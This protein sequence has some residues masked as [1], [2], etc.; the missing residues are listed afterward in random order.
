VS[1]QFVAN[2][3]AANSNTGTVTIDVLPVNDAPSA[4]TGVSATIN[5]DTSAF[6]TLAELLAGA[7]DID[8]GTLS[9]TALDNNGQIFASFDT[10]G[11]HV[12]GFAV[13]QNGPAVGFYTVSDGQGGTS[14]GTI[15]L[16]ILPVN[17]APTVASQTFAGTEDAPRLFS[18]A[19]LL[20]D[21]ADD[22]DGDSLSLVSITS[23]SGGMV[24]VTGDVVTFTPNADFN[25]TAWFFLTVTDGTLTGGNWQYIDFADVNDVPTAAAD[26]VTRSGADP[27]VIA[28]SAL[29]ANDGDIDSPQAGWSV[30]LGTATGGTVSLNGNGDVVFDFN[31]S[32]VGAYSFTYQVDDGEGG[33]S[34]LATV[35]LNTAPDAAEDDATVAEN[36]AY[37]SWQRVEVLDNDNDAD[38]DTL[39]VTGASLVGS[40]A[41]I[42]VSWDAD[43]VRFYST[44][45]AWFGAFEISYTIS[46]GRG[47]TDTALVR[48]TVTPSD[49]APTVTPD[50]GNST[51]IAST[52]ELT[53]IVIP[54]SALLANDSHEDGTSFTIT[55]VEIFHRGTA[56]LI[57]TDADTIM[58]SVRFTPQVQ[59]S[60]FYDYSNSWLAYFYYTVTDAD[61]DTAQTYAYVRVNDVNQA[62]DAVGETLAR[63]ASPQVIA[64]DTLFVN[65]VDFDSPVAGWTISAITNQN[66]VTV[67][68]DNTART[69]TVTYDGGF[70][71]TYGF[72]Y[73]LSDG[74]G[75]TDTASVI[76]DTAPQ[77]TGPVG[78]LVLNEDQAQYVSD[79]T[80]IALAGVT[81][82]DG[83]PLF[84]V[85]AVAG[86]N[87]YALDGFNTVYV[88]NDPADWNG[89]TELTFTVSDGHPGGQIT[90]TIPVTITA[91]NDAPRDPQGNDQAL[92]LTTAEDTP[93][94]ISVATLL[95]DDANPANEVQS[96]SLHDLAFW[97]NGNVVNNNNGTLTFSP[98]ANFNGT[99]GFWY[100][101]QDEQGAVSDY[102]WVPI[103]VTPVEDPVD[104]VNDVVARQFPNAGTQR[105]AFSTLLGND[106]DPDSDGTITS[107]TAGANV[108][109]VVIDGNEV[110]V[111]YTSGAATFTYTLS[112][113]TS[114]DT[115][116]VTLNS[117]PVQTGTPGTLTINEDQQ[118]YLT[119]DQLIALAGVTDPNGDNLY[120][121][122]Y[123]TNGNFSIQRFWWYSEYAYYTP[124]PLD[125]NGDTTLTF[126]I[127]DGN[128]AT[129]LT[130]TIDV[131]VL[132]INDGPRDRDSVAGWGNNRD[133][134]FY[135]TEDTDLVILKADLLADDVDPEGGVVSFAQAYNAFSLGYIFAQDE[136]SITI[137]P[138][139]NASGEGLGFYYYS[140]DALGQWS[141]PIYVVI[142][143]AETPDAINAIDDTITRSGAS[144]TITAAQMTGNDVDPDV[145]DTKD[146]VSVSAVNGLT[147]VV[148]N[149]NDS[150]T[151]TYDASYTGRASYTYT[152]Q[153]SQGNSDTATVELNR[154]PVAV[155]DGTFTLDEGQ[156][157][158]FIAYSTLLA[159]DSDADGD[160][161]S[162]S[163][164]N[165]GYAGS[166]VS[167]STGWFEGGEFGLR[168]YLYDTTYTGPAEFQYRVWD[169]DTYS[170]I[171][172]VT[173]NSVEGNDA[174]VARHDYWFYNG[175]VYNDTNPAT[176]PMAGTEDTVLEFAASL[177][178]DGQFIGGSYVDGAD[179]DEDGDAISI[180]AGSLFSS[181]GTVQLIGDNIV[182]TPNADVNSGYPWGSQE[183]YAIS[184][185]YRVTDGERESSTAT[186]YIY[187]APVDDAPITEDD[188]FGVFGNGPWTLDI[189]NLDGSYNVRVNDRSPD[190]YPY[191]F[192]SGY[193]TI[194][195]VYAITG[196]A[197]L[198]WD[199]YQVTVT[200]DGSGD[201]IVF[202]YVITDYD[203]DSATAQ[204][205]L[206]PLGQE[207]QRFYFSGSVPDYGRELWV[208]DPASYDEFLGS[209][210]A[211]MV[212]EADMQPGPDSGDPREIT[213]LGGTVFWRGSQIVDNEGGS[214][215][216]Y[217]WHAYSPSLGYIQLSRDV[218]F[219]AF[220][221][222]LP[223]EQQNLGVRAGDLFW[224]ASYIEG[225]SLIAWNQAGAE[226]A[227]VYLPG[228]DRELLTDAGGQPAY[229][230][231]DYTEVWNPE[232]GSTESFDAEQLFAVLHNSWGWEVVRITDDGTADND[233]REIAATSVQDDPSGSGLSVKHF[234]FAG[235]FGNDYQGSFTNGLWRVTTTTYGSGWDSY[236]QAELISDQLVAA[237]PHDLTIAK[238]S[239]GAGGT[240]D[241][242]FWFQ[243]NTDGNGEL[244]TRREDYFGGSSSST[245]TLFGSESFTG[246]EIRQW[247]DGVVFSGT[248]SGGDFVALYVDH[249][250]GV[251]E[252]FYIGVVL[253]LDIAGEVEQLV[254][255]GLGNTAWIV[256]DGTFDTVWTYNGDSVSFV[257]SKFGEVTDLQMAGGDIVY[258]AQSDNDPYFRTLF[259]YDIAS[260][261]LIEVPTDE[262]TEAGPAD[263]FG[264]YSGNV[265]IAGGL[266][267]DANDGSGTRLWLTDGSTITDVGGTRY[268][269]VVGY[270]GD[271]IGGG[272]FDDGSGAADGL[273]R[274]TS[275]GVVTQ[276]DDLDGIGV[277]GE[278]E[279]LGDRV[280]YG[281]NAGGTPTVRA[282]DLV[283]GTTSTV[284]AGYALGTAEQVGSEMIFS[285]WHAATSTWDLFSWNGASATYLADLPAT[286]V[287]Y[288]PSGEWRGEL[289]FLGD[290]DH[291]FFKYLSTD[292]GEEVFVLDRAT[293]TIAEL[294]IRPG[295]DSGANWGDGVFANGRV[296]FQASADGTA[297][298]M[299]LYTTTD[300]SDL[301]IV[302]GPDLST[303]YQFPWLPEVIGNTVYFLANS[304]FAASNTWAVFAVNADGISGNADDTT[305]TMIS[306]DDFSFIYSLEAI[307]GDLYFAEFEGSADQA[308]RMTPGAAP[309]QLTSFINGGS[310]SDFFEGG[311][312][313]I[314]FARDDGDY[315]REL[316]VLDDAEAVG[317]RLV[318][319]INSGF[320]NGGYEPERV[321]PAPDSL[322]YLRMLE[323]W[324]SSGGGG[325]IET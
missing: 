170:N 307:G 175:A 217:R 98:N 81:D 150:V 261:T 200:A 306:P 295:A 96:V 119:D 27:Q 205:T 20:A 325:G 174:P 43:E 106:I 87:L 312:G 276:L 33:L 103:T 263:G 314:Y 145:G 210:F 283:G 218:A 197:T 292:F 214:Y 29:F 38:G 206:N 154:A 275:A 141:A 160:P 296:F 300:G 198:S 80:L 213:A 6:F 19:A 30:V 107:V 122:G 113:G 259:S 311:D 249:D 152:V 289:D 135:G 308:W 260:A 140:Q 146:I 258:V 75:G 109:S 234:Y 299:R 47:A 226:V 279:L 53:P 182:F 104:A 148:L 151:V 31:P 9:V 44:D 251:D 184:F 215:A 315:G 48:V 5:E 143:L 302:T 229:A 208:Y 63:S 114:T 165:W 191:G 167:I 93:I 85:S 242:L 193:T 156:N 274:I 129:D 318:A 94:V 59:N 110:V 227:Q 92:G 177:L 90:V 136:T 71:G 66:G 225:E 42:V 54:F 1:F 22:V 159:N 287:A 257:A 228:Y 83:D 49:D 23:V 161:I 309:V 79:A 189:G 246:R 236:Q 280:L 172:T 288:T 282:H 34:G 255:D 278:V 158:V 230:A 310:V 144:Q 252:N 224:G 123:G 102:V 324:Y 28:K 65:D 74:E 82:A 223:L 195:D 91:V 244:A 250:T 322:D 69:V 232:T 163:P 169:G 95:A 298:S 207:P 290:S 277:R 134:I 105:I 15:T 13:N 14:T 201:P 108:S 70:A 116:T 270:A 58:D 256:D 313:A 196:I 297:D 305:A 267:F 220:D 166:N 25:G 171:V 125:F 37:N 41:P 253:M 265:A 35:T 24:D 209:P 67:A 17:D 303:G 221:A 88:V 76:L 231:R 60:N 243:T 89:A 248:A 186:A 238:V 130:V 132:P 52:D 16:N 281:D 120:I 233:I 61:G 199:G 262:P 86:A 99:A 149:A 284:L 293:N 8:G 126:T 304:V 10:G 155:G 39:T 118:T 121:S 62:P 212:D 179:S 26:Q 319:D 269:S 32:H 57:D 7:S 64:F 56:E 50:F 323:A 72:D 204:V 176:N 78:T 211:T 137:R 239:D 272:R 164:Y 235:D 100:R 183:P 316:W 271:W 162:V 127:S 241:R 285:A 194:T 173:L 245:G 320:I 181:Y 153:D 138:Y 188:S 55:S 301:E 73:T 117:G 168:A 124:V 147:S 11:I 185:S 18:V 180:V 36:D 131:D 115:A 97:G 21:L 178:I 45:S 142:N 128:A 237:N 77:Q 268:S 3:G 68:V 139:A 317:A 133:G 84:I 40:S 266:A 286:G 157:Y 291:L 264:G 273:Y 240:W 222:S 12:S 321:T 216:A 192:Y 294:D 51:P 190:D 2:D 202:E 101:T 247:Q 112:D 203:G 254:V 4:P 187:L 111:T 219:Y 46:D